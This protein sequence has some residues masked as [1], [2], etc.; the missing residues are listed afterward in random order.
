[1]RVNWPVFLI[2]AM[3]ATGMGLIFGAGAAGVT[4]LVCAIIIGFATAV[5]S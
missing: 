3:L 5:N 1:M 4:L 2:S